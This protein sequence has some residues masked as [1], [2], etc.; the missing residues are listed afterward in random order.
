MGEDCEVVRCRAGQYDVLWGSG[1]AKLLVSVHAR[2]V[3]WTLTLVRIGVG[4]ILQ[5]LLC[6][7]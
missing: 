2:Q 7:L 3:G 1:C 6:C 5:T 4:N